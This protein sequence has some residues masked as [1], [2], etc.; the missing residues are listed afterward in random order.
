MYNW[1]QNDWPEFTYNL[2]GLEEKLFIFAERVGRISG[3]WETLPED[4]Q[5]EA[6]INMMVA[7]AIKTSEIEGEYISRKDVISSIRNNLGL[8]SETE[9]IIDKRAAGVSEL[10][11]DVRKTYKKPLSEKKLF[12]WHSM[13]MGESGGIKVGAWRTHKET[14]QVVSGAI[15]KEKVHYEAPPSSRV[16][17]EMNQFIE[18]F[19]KTAPEGQK[20]IK[21]APIR[22]AI[23]HLY[24]ET[25]HPFE[26]GN[27]RIGRAIAEKALSQGIGR[28][29]LIS[30]SERIESNKKEYYG[31][32]KKAQRSNQITDWVH[33]FVNVILEAQVRAE[34]QIDFTLKKVKFY[35]RYKDRLNERH[36]KVIHRILEE[37]PGGFKGGMNTRKYIG[38]TK[39]SKSTAT[40]DLQY[41]LE[42]GAFSRLGEAGGR[43]TRYQI[44]LP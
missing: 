8:K 1:Q 42:I 29:A 9:N 20:E 14:M 43:S 11:I 16:P 30:L 18:W 4:T 10:M 13:L 26:D 5:Q 7:E 28:P 2:S 33:Y 3:I 36:Q 31:A 19:N 37:G 23:A 34:A 22:S 39:T 41:L 24:F 32:L 35:D 21:Q 25:V 27:G 40:R 38:I 44:N 17:Q 12:I 6:M 15:G